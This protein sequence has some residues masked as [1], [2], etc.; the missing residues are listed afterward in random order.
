M[1][2]IASLL[3]IGLCL[4]AGLARS[5]SGQPLQGR[6]SNTQQNQQGNSPPTEIFS[7]GSTGTQ[8]VV[9]NPN[10]PPPT[11]LGGDHPRNWSCPTGTQGVVGNPNC[12]PPTLPGGGHPRNWSC[13]TGTQNPGGRP[14]LSGYAETSP[15]PGGTAPGPAQNGRGTPSPGQGDPGK[16]LRTGAGSA[17]TAACFPGGY[18]TTN[19]VAGG[20]NFCAN[21]T[22]RGAPSGCRCFSKTPSTP[23][24]WEAPAQAQN[25]QTQGEPDPFLAGVRDGTRGCAVGYENLVA[26]AGAFG[27]GD[28]VRAQTLLGID[29]TD[30]ARQF[31]IALAGDLQTPVVGKPPTPYANGYRI[32]RRLCMYATLWQPK[33]GKPGT[34]APPRS[35]AKGLESAGADAWAGQYHVDPFSG[36][37]FQVMGRSRVPASH[38]TSTNANKG[39]SLAY[40][41][42][43]FDQGEI[44]LQAPA[45]ANVA[46]VDF[47]T[48]ARQAGTGLM[49]II[50]SDVK[51]SMKGNFP[52][53]KSVLPGTWR[54]E[55]LDAVQRL[56]LGDAGLEGE[57][58][59]ALTQNRI[60]MRQL[61]VDLAPGAQ[62]RSG[63]PV[64]ISGW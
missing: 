57:I 12:P 63:Q 55:V 2:T 24:P 17:A 37:R 30:I 43:R 15:G 47:I 54:A 60:R 49:E 20:Y 32:S 51:T 3:L 48:A 50:V 1:R 8:G 42:A 11:L 36:E 26:A 59:D 34:V 10:C 7:S 53:A 33:A 19:G 62:G 28:F 16:W 29:K 5:Q 41:E 23:W 6:V 64:N 13:P 25:R 9:A 35:W 56:R 58:A 27:R 38:A 40:H 39:E 31:L 14:P 18:S 52:A 4:Y 61:N 45:G 21:P 22:L 44:G 46:G